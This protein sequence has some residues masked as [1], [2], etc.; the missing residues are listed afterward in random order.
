MAAVNSQWALPAGQLLE[1]ES[2]PGRLRIRQLN[3]VPGFS[4]T[5]VDFTEMRLLST[6]LDGR[7]QRSLADT[8]TIMSNS[9]TP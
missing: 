1:C 7:R 6:M 2:T 4:I 8:V 5:A 3:R 9:L